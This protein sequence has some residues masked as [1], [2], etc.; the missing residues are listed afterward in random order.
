MSR[1]GCCYDNAVMES[2]FHTLK[3]EFVSHE[4]FATKQQAKDAII[5]WIEVF[6]NRERL[7]S[8]IG[9]KTPVAYQ[10]ELMLTV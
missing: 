6:Y 4:K 7:H 9:Y 1:G 5:E 3:T 10:E 8:S 2:F